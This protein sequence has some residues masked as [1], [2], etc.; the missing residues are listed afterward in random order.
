MSFGRNARLASVPLCIIAYFVS[1]P[2]LLLAQQGASATHFGPGALHTSSTIGSVS[3]GRAAQA[4]GSSNWTAGKG[5]FRSS[6]QPGGVWREGSTFSAARG[7]SGSS[8]LARRPNEAGFAS[9]GNPG[10]GSLSPRP[11]GLRGGAPSGTAHFSGSSS[12]QRFGGGAFGRSSASKSFGPK[13]GAARSQSRGMGTSGSQPSSGLRTGVAQTSSRQG[14]PGGSL[15]HGRPN[16]S[17]TRSGP[18]ALP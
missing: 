16:T 9:S 2:A 3:S 8:P 5:S 14:M 4:G 1:M 15:Q 12:G 13:F 11:T 18:G 10:S 6:V 7:T 17:L